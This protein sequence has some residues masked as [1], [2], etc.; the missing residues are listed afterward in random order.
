MTTNRMQDVFDERARRFAAAE[1]A[2]GMADPVDVLVYTLGGQRYAVALDALAEV[3]V[4]PGATPVPG[5]P[6]M[7][8]GVANVRGRLVLALDPRVLLDARGA[9]ASKGYFIVLREEAGSIGMRVDAVEEMRRIDRAALIPVH[10]DTTSH[11]TLPIITA[12]T[13]DGAS[14]VDAQALARR[15]RSELTHTKESRND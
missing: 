12:L 8:S 10:R 15:F 3:V 13:S 9:A 6:A 1:T 7:L 5:S 2:S 11:G 4:D 14:L